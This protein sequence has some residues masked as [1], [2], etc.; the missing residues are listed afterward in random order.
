M[1]TQN[2][3]IKQPKSELT[4]T[5]IA[6]TFLELIKQK[7]WD[8]ITVKEICNAADITRGTFY[9]YFNDIYDLMEQIQKKLLDDLTKRYESILNIPKKSFPW[10]DFVEKFDY[11]PPESLIT[12]FRFCNDKKPAIAALLDPEHGDEYFCKKLKNKLNEYISDMMDHDDMKSD[13]LREYFSKVFL[14]LHFL[15]ARTWVTSENNAFLTPYELIQLI[16][17]MRVGAN[18]LTF[19]NRTTTDFDEKMWRTDLFTNEN[20]K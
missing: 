1:S 17:S 20:Q 6:D 2:Y 19:K 15:V 4:R 16:N 5:K 10:E 9:Q 3:E 14:E 12:W 7:K 11:T 18:Y 8:R 13:A